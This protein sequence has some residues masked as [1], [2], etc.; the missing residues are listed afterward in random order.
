[1]PLALEEFILSEFKL[2]NLN[3]GGAI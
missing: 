1:M 3:V 2:V